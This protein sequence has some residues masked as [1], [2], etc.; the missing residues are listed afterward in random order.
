MKELTIISGKGGTGKTTV[1]AAFAALAERK[2]L[3]DC[4]VDAANLHLLLDPT[5]RRVEPFSAMR[6]PRIDPELCAE[7]GICQ[8]QCRFDAIQLDFDAGYVIDELACEHCGLCAR[9][10]PEWAIQMEDHFCG[11]WMVSD[12]RRGTLVH[13]RLGI[14]EDNSGKLVTLVRREARRLAEEEGAE[15]ILNDGPPGIGCPVTAAITGVDLVLAVTEPT[16]SGL[17]DLQR[18]AGLCEHFR[19]P[20][21]VCIN[22]HDLSP[23]NTA[24]MHDWC[25]ERDIE[26][27]GAIPFDPAVHRALA[28]RQSLIDAGDSAAAEA[29]T[30]LW[31]RVEG[32]LKPN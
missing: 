20:L 4:D 31:E 6:S 28:A 7:C 27:L 18:V 15:L 30:M 2:V 9:V 29:V 21:T 25:A 14:G 23:E 3:A 10:C 24:G 13:A 5:P 8:S 11:D 12:T 1:S 16:P 26:I 22:K 17:H 32:R 19:I